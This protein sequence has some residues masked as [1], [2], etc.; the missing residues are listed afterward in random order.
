MSPMFLNISCYR[1]AASSVDAI[2]VLN[3]KAAEYE[4]IPIDNIAD[5]VPRLAITRFTPLGENERFAYTDD[6]GVT[7][8]AVR[9][10]D[11]E[12]I[13]ELVFLGDAM[14]HSVQFTSDLRRSFFARWRLPS[15]LPLR[16]RVRSPIYMAN[17]ETG[18]IKRLPID[19]DHWFRVSND[20][21]FVGF[22]DPYVRSELENNR[23][24]TEREQANVFIFDIEAE[25]MTEFQWRT[26]ARADGGWHI[27]RFDNGFRI[28]GLTERGDH[29]MA[30]AEIDLS[31]MEL[32]TLWDRTAGSDDTTPLPF[33]GDDWFDDVS[34]QFRNPNVRL[35]RR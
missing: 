35:Q 3:I 2:E 28:Y 21:R 33:F 14:W 25:T 23:R 32:T 17:G 7:L 18:E 24:I 12:D 19:A 31:T 20:G 26:N 15:D 29:I 22:I 5:N 34:L 11:I 9:N 30:A 13:S 16:Y 27:H 10:N 1:D 6:A 8:Y 4:I